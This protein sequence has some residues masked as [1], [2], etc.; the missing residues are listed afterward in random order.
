PCDVWL[1][2]W[3]LP[4]RAGDRFHG[5]RV[6]YGDAQ[7]RRDREGLLR[8]R[9]TPRGLA[10]EGGPA[11]RLEVVAELLAGREG[12]LAGQHVHRAIQVTLTGQVGQ[13]PVLSRVAGRPVVDAVEVGLVVGEQVTVPEDDAVGRTA[14]VAP[15]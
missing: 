15:Q 3:S 2:D 13:A 14:T 12:G 7:R 5:T 8:M 4:C 11:L 6:R 10:D 9:P 1:E